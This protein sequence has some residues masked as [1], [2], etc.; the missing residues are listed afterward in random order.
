MW[1]CVGR[2]GFVE[3]AGCMLVHITSFQFAVHKR[4]SSY[5]V[6]TKQVLKLTVIQLYMNLSQ[7]MGFVS[8]SVSVISLSITKDSGFLPFPHVFVLLFLFFIPCM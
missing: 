2:C 3:V 7:V 4:L 6:T 8:L 5:S 1:V